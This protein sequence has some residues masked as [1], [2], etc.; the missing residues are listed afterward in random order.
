MSTSPISKPIQE[1]N[2][3]RYSESNGDSG[4]AS[5]RSSSRRSKSCMSICMSSSISQ[6]MDD[7]GGGRIEVEV[8]G[9]TGPLEL[10][11]EAELG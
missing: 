7:L 2:E 11:V 9:V 6:G 3:L 10:T 8:R 5:F 4:H 1:L